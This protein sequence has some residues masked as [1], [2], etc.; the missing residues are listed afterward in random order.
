MVRGLQ[1]GYRKKE[2]KTRQEMAEGSKNEMC[3]L[4]EPFGFEELFQ[5]GRAG[6]VSR[7]SYHLTSAVSM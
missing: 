5:T 2:E 7:D 4:L 6:T 1:N 3:K